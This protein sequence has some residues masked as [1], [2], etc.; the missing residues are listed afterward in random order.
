M[1]AFP[2]SLAPE[3]IYEVTN[4]V[5]ISK[6]LNR[7]RKVAC[8]EAPEHRMFDYEAVEPNDPDRGHKQR[9]TWRDK[10]GAVTK[11]RIG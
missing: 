11:V 3:L 10:A 8:A 9:F 5:L 7:L 1:H 2:R 6:F 4:G